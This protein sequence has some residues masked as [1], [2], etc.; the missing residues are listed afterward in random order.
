MKDILQGQIRAAMTIVGKVMEHA[1]N[2]GT[3]APPVFTPGQKQRIKT[4]LFIAFAEMVNA[5]QVTTEDEEPDE[6]SRATEGATTT[7]QDGGNG[8]GKHA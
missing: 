2:D 5:V 1:H 3:I 6:I 7:E 8:H 4:A